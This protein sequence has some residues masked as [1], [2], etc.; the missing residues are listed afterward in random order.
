MRS[1]FPMSGS[2]RNRSVTLPR[3]APAAGLVVAVGAGICLAGPTST[4]SAGGRSVSLLSG[5]PLMIEALSDRRRNMPSTARAALSEIRRWTHLAWSSVA[6]ILGVSRKTVHNWANGDEPKGHNLILLTQLHSRS[7]ELNARHGAAM[8]GTTLAIEHG[9][10]ARI[11]RA[12]PRIMP[13]NVPAILTADT[14]AEGP[15]LQVVGKRS[16][17]RLAEA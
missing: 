14:T 17:V 13:S 11:S 7:H 5:R 2:V 10:T 9:V 4:Q 3:C 15:A 16:R 12:S 6:E 8:A 1:L